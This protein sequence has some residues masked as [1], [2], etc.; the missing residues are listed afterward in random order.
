MRKIVK[1][2]LLQNVV[3]KTEKEFR[4]DG[5]TSKHGSSDSDFGF[6]AYLKLGTGEPSLFQENRDS[7]CSSFHTGEDGSPNLILL[8]ETQFLCSW[9][10]LSILTLL[11]AFLIYSVRISFHHCHLKMRAAKWTLWNILSRHFLFLLLLN[12]LG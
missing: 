7:L 4:K 5:S 1:F 8:L 10:L 6:L 12:V 9:G 11:L 2:P 3:C